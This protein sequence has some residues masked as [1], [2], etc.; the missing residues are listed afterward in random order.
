MKNGQTLWRCT[1]REILRNTNAATVRDWCRTAGINGAATRAL[2]GY[3]EGASNE[4]LARA[5]G[6]E[7]RAL[8]ALR[9]RGL[10]QLR[11]FL[12]ANP[13]VCPSFIRFLAE[14]APPDDG[15]RPTI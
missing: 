3:A 14:I 9:L 2:M 7:V 6:C 15:P 13:A 11:C 12:V 4:Q 8:S 1:L 5:L 10:R